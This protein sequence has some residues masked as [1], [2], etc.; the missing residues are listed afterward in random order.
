MTA[1]HSFGNLETVMGGHLAIP[2]FNNCLVLENGA[3]LSE[4]DGLILVDGEF[5][6][7]RMGKTL[8][9]KQNCQSL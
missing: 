1:I 9:H 4:Q 5:Q 6:N 7:T 3:N 8:K 2:I